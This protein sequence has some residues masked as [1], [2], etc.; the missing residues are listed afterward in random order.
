M[1]LMTRP[2]YFG[3]TRRVTRIDPTRSELYIGQLMN[4]MNFSEVLLLQKLDAIINLNSLYLWMKLPKMNALYLVGMDI[5]LKIH[6]QLKKN[7][8]VWGIRY[9]ILPALSLQGIIAVDI[10]EG[11]CTK[12]KFKEFVISN[13]VCWIISFIYYLLLLQL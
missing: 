11:N 13:V 9:T 10:M 4:E 6:L 3:S 1:N 2:E 7:V 5:L 12:E 8:F